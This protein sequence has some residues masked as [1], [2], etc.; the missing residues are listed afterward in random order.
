MSNTKRFLSPGLYKEGLRQLCPAG[1]LFA[2]LCAGAPFAEVIMTIVSVLSKTGDPKMAMSNFTAISA[3]VFVVVGI[4][5]AASVFTLFR[6]LNKR[7]SSDFY[8]ALAA[9]RLTL[10][11]S[12]LA[13]ILTWVWGVGLL[14]L[15]LMAAVALIGGVPLTLSTIVVS[16]GLLLSAT[17]FVVAA[18]LVAVSITGV[19][20]MNLIVLVLIIMLPYAAASAFTQAVAGRVPSLPVEFIGA[21]GTVSLHNTLFMLVGDTSLYGVATFVASIA[22]TALWSL[23]LIGV[24]AWFFKHRLSELA[25]SV[26]V[27]RGFLLVFRVALAIL[28][29]ALGTVPLA[30]GSGANGLMVMLPTSFS[31]PTSFMV[32]LRYSIPLLIFILVIFLGVEFLV[33]RKLKSVWRALPSFSLVL[34]FT[35]AFFGAIFLYSTSA[36]RFAPSSSQIASVQIITSSYGVVTDSSSPIFSTMFSSS[37][38]PVSFNDLLTRNTVDDDPALLQATAAKLREPFSAA[39]SINSNGDPTARLIAIRMKDGSMVHR[40]ITIRGGSNPDAFERALLKS[41]KIA[42]TLLRL[43]K[44]DAQMRFSGLA[45]PLSAGDSSTMNSVTVNATPQQYFVSAAQQ[46][47]AYRSLYGLFYA[48]YQ[49]LSPEE[50]YQILYGDQ[51]QGQ[52]TISAETTA[53]TDFIGGG[54]V[55]V[56]GVSGAQQFSNTYNFSTPKA[57]LRYWEMECLD[58]TTA[59]TRAPSRVHLDELG[60]YTPS[61]ERGIS[62]DATSAVSSDPFW[63][64]KSARFVAAVRSGGTTITITEADGSSSTTS[65]DDD[66]TETGISDATMQQAETII[67]P[68][69]SRKFNLNAPVLASISVNYYDETNRKQ[70]SQASIT[71]PLTAQEAAALQALTK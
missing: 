63:A 32:L 23:M 61:A 12:F 48:E 62:S 30:V 68:A 4:F 40:L 3:S 6:F 29:V 35:L 56:N 9:P 46:Q 42:D 64:V 5:A 38:S 58:M 57:L 49:K 47:R 36:K 34:V 19:R 28:V 20:F 39:D 65:I 26:T 8:H 16:L 51:S 2:V 55:Q 66:P 15:L 11:F 7:G 71:V 1:I 18:T 10:Y 14:A 44:P 60:L 45:F 13:A 54:S 37:D 22:V 43:P 24:G 21:I 53:V 33:T 50:Q 25:G 70:L 69:L 41:P 17:L 52:V 31:Q 67:K 59:F 27:S